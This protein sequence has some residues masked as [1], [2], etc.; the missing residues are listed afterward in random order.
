MSARCLLIV[1]MLACLTGCGESM[2]TM[3]PAKGKV[4]YKGQPLKFGTVMFQPSSG[5]SA[6]G[7]IQPD[8][9][10]DLSTERYGTGPAAPG[11]AVGLHSVRITCYEGQAPAAPNGGDQERPLG[12]S[13][14]PE[15]Y[16]NVESSGLKAEVKPDAPPFLFELKDS[17]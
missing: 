7:E 4:T 6:K 13:L 5:Q 10:F 3:A 2:P 15:H 8:G 11:A 1:G 14:I 9:T 17:K 16:T 12:R